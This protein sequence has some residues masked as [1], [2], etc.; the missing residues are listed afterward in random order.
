MKE[1]KIIILGN[2]SHGFASLLPLLEGR[3]ITTVQFL[4]HSEDDINADYTKYCDNRKVSPY[5]E[6][7]ALEYASLKFLFWKDK[8]NV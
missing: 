7:I 6:D 5:E 1:Q 2:G 3:K 8:Y 4:L